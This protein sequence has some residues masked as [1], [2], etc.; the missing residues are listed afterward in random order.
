[1]ILGIF[2]SSLLPGSAATEPGCE[3]RE[4]DEILEVNG[5]SLI[6][7]VREGATDFLKQVQLGDTV[8]LLLSQEPKV[9]VDPTNEKA[10][11]KHTAL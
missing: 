2:V 5:H 1:L 4:G 8:T 9:W 3:V 11:L 10:A 6:G 7:V